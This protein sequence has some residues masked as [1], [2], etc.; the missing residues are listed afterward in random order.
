[1]ERPEGHRNSGSSHDLPETLFHLICRILRDI[2]AYESKRY[3]ARRFRELYR[4][5]ESEKKKLRK[6]S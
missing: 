2:E 5:Y 6:K 1:M 4:L 3:G